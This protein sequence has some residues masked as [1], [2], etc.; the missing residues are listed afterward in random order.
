MTETRGR[1]ST[2][3]KGEVGGSDTGN[4]QQKGEGAGAEKGDQR[5]EKPTHSGP[6]RGG[7]QGTTNRRAKRSG[8]DSNASQ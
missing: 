3:P 2:D 6:T 4:S 1:T 7:T 8:S 5:R